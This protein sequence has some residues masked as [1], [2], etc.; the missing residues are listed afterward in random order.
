MFENEDDRK[1]HTGYYIPKV[2]IKDCNVMIDKK[3]YF[4]QSVKSNMRTSDNIRKIKRGQREDYT[5]G[6]LLDYNYFKKHYAKMTIDLNKQQALDADTKAIKQI[7][8][9][10]NLDR[11]GNTT[12]LFIIEET[13]KTILE[14][15]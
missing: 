3:N 11:D 15:S 13:K 7:N 8:F 2:K 4:E 6:C 1:V 5:T 14:F 12:M 10:G 9:T